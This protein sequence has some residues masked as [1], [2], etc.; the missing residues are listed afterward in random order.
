MAGV[1]RTKLTRLELVEIHKMLKMRKEL[2]AAR[3]K[4]EMAHIDADMQLLERL[5]RVELNQEYEGT[6][7]AQFRTA[8]GTF[9]EK[10]AVAFRVQDREAL[11]EFVSETDGALSLFGNTLSKE[12]GELILSR[13]RKERY[14]GIEAE[15]TARLH[16]PPSEEEMTAALSTVAIPGV[17]RDVFMRVSFRKA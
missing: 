13:L 11:D 17:R 3:H 6:G 8:G 14:A 4:A 10:E 2:M 16:R 7:I 12:D 5:V 1:A 9:F 15:L